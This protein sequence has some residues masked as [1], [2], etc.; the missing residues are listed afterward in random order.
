ME[1][2]RMRRSL[3]V[4]LLMAQCFAYAQNVDGDA[5]ISNTILIDIGPTIVMGLMGHGPAGSLEYAFRLSDQFFCRAFVLGS[6]YSNMYIWGLGGGID[7]VPN[8]KAKPEGLL[9]SLVGGCGAAGDG[10]MLT[11]IRGDVG[12]QKIWSSGMTF[13]ISGGL[14]LSI[15]MLP[16]LPVAKLGFGY[17]F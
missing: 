11:A 3:F 9:L 2:D 17:S 14:L 12:Y 6:V 4:F 15:S 7:Y 10:G 13:N 16:V 5:K 1:G 8:G